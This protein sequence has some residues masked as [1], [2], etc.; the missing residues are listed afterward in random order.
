MTIGTNTTSSTQGIYF[1]TDVNLYRSGP[2]S[3]T[4]N[5]NLYT[6]GL[7][8]QTLQNTAWSNFGTQNTTDDIVDYY[9][10]SSALVGKVG[11]TGDL[12]VKPST[13]S[14]TAF[15]VQN[16]SGNALLTVD[17][18]NGA[19]DIPND[20]IG[21]LAVGSDGIIGESN[22]DQTVYIRNNNVSSK[23]SLQGAKLD[24]EDT[25]N[26]FA[27]EFQISNGGANHLHKRHQLRQRLPD[28]ECQR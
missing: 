12:L 4:T 26:S 14:T 5:S 27:R 16:V 10:S 6:Y 18:I 2:I 25:V 15:K 8:V 19:V 11:A 9:N 24:F 22:S 21:V 1:G 23:V 28:P 20:N 3:L 7:S 17:T 13:N